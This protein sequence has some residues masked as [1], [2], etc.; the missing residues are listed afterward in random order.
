[1]QAGNDTRAIEGTTTGA[2]EVGGLGFGFAVSGFWFLVTSAVSVKILQA[3]EPN[4]RLLLKTAD[5]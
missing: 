3:K 4:Q 2:A 1:L 5:Y